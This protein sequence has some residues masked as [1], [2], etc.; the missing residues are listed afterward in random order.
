MNTHE[1]TNQA[2][3]RL[4]YHRVDHER[5]G[6]LCRRLRERARA[7]MLTEQIVGDLSEARLVLW[8]L[9]GGPPDA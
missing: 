2:L 8:L 4:G 6:E 5:G 7:G 3:R 1:T 9:Q